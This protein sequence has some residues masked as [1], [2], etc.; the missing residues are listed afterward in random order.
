MFYLW[1]ITFLYG[2]LLVLRQPL[3]SYGF[4]LDPGSRVLLEDVPQVLLGQ[5]EE[6]GVAHGP[7]TGC[8]S[9]ARCAHIENTDLTKVATWLQV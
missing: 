7:D 4:Q 2:L 5:T 9:V 3:D 1:N 6:V 8:P